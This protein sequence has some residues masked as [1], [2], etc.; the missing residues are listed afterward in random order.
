MMYLQTV[1]RRKSVTA[2]WQ[3]R[4]DRKRRREVRRGPET[5]CPPPPGQTRT[6]SHW[7]ISGRQD[8]TLTG[9]VTVMWGGRLWFSWRPARYLQ[10]GWRKA[11]G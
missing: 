9:P 3:N 1:W 8:V 5:W 11:E 4:E 6:E 10:K 2:G 7:S